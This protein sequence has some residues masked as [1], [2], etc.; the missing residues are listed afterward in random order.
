M[1]NKMPKLSDFS[2]GQRSIGKNYCLSLFNIII[3]FGY[4]INLT[5]SQFIGSS[6]E[7]ETGINLTQNTI[8][9]KHSLIKC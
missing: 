7:G 6:T 8:Q 1:K 3:Q 9:K 2:Q 4:F 5:I